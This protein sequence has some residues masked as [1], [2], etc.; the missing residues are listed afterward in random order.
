MKVLSHED[1]ALKNG[2]GTE[3]AASSASIT[4][5]CGPTGGFEGRSRAADF[6]RALRC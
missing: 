3:V 2:F 1:D 4:D 5:L 6:L